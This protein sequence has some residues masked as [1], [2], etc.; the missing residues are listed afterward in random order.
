MAGSKACEELTVETLVT[1][2]SGTVG[3]LINMLE[4]TIALLGALLKG[5]EVLGTESSI[6][7]SRDESNMEVPSRDSSA[8]VGM[9]SRFGRG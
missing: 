3:P 2:F 5:V 1:V 9:E 6:C 4:V 8:S 7:S